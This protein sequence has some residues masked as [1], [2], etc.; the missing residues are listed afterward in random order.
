MI[1]TQLPIRDLMVQYA[2]SFLGKPYIWG[3]AGGLGIDCSGLC[4]EI[5]QGVGLLPRSLDQTANDL[6]QRFSRTEEP[7]HGNLIF[8]VSDGRAFHTGLVAYDGL[9]YI[10]AEGGGSTTTT[11]AEANGR[12]AY[13]KL[14]PLESRGA[15]LLADP[16]KERRLR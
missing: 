11:L 4:V 12:N 13:V 10:G 9:A 14:R 8:W 7:L 16:F 3:G 1:A 6:F 15:Y 5:L 2:W